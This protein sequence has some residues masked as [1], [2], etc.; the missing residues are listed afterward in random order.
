M[1]KNK[2]Q[3]FIL[4]TTMLIFIITASIVLPYIAQYF[5][6]SRS[7]ERK[8]VIDEVQI[9]GIAAQNFYSEFSIFPDEN[10]A[11]IS[12]LAVMTNATNS[13]ITGIDNTSPWG[14]NY[15]FNCTT[16][17]FNISVAL[18]NDHAAI[19]ANR[20]AA[21]SANGATITTAVPIPS[22]MPALASFLAQDAS[23]SFDARSNK[24]INVTD[25]EL[26]TVS[27][28]LLNIINNQ[29]QVFTVVNGEEVSKPNCPPHL[30]ENINLGLAGLVAT[31]SKIPYP[32]PPFIASS[33]S[34]SWTIGIDIYTEDGVG[35]AATGT[36]A[37][38][39]VNCV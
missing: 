23:G 11:C 18:D 27:D 16:N 2:Q 10:N 17:L 7:E 22:F 37:L 14:T 38:A 19:V 32:N 26:T 9:L 4:M 35:I 13:F 30:S 15:N 5:S 21:T 33:D 28:T 25:I 29:T 20:L 31:N 34:D 3:G 8:A 1:N 12:A 24:I 39:I 36:Y 6:G